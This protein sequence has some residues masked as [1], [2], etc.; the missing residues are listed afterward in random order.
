M[1]ILVWGAGFFG[2][3]WIETVRARADCQVAGVIS[4]S[5]ERVAELRRDPALA[6]VPAHTGLEEAAAGGRADALIVALPQMLHREAILKALEA[7]FHVLTEKPLAM[8]MDDARAIFQAT[9]DHPD[10]AVMVNQN[11]RWRPHTLALRRAVR[12]GRIGRPGRA[13]F[14]C[15]QRVLRK[16]VEGWREDMPEPFLLD[17]AIHHCDLMRYL[18]GQEPREVV[19]VSFQPAWSWYKGNAAAAA[20]VTMQDGLVVSYGGTMVSQGLDTPQEGL[21]T[22]TGEQG[23]LHLDDR[24]QVNLLGQGE[25][26]VIPHES[27]PEGELGHGLAEFLD[28]IRT[29]R[30]P[31]THVGDNIRSLALLLAI[32][33]SVRRREPVRPADLLNFL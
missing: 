17:Y 22:L 8:T 31:E 5:A 11:F 19:G 1:R 6:G 7:G 27:V 29:R 21:I 20:I 30:L 3:K 15:R 18:T 16:T 4:R 10:R 9:R 32:L 13:V 28:A 25:P 26:R 24:C 23:T 12:E 33:E 14:E 2:R